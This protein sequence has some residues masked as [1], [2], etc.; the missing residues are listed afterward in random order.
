MSAP[1]F[2]VVMPVYNVERYLR[3]AADSVLGQAFRDF[4]L[5]LVDD[6]SSDGSRA[7]CDEIA[8]AD[9]RVRV[10]RR[11]ENGGLGAARNTGMDGAAGKYIFFM[12]SD[13]TVDA[14]LLED[15][16]RALDENPAEVTVFGVTEEYYTPAGE[17]DHSN[18]VDC[19]EECRLS[20]YGEVRAAVLPMEEKQ[21]FGYVWNKIYRADYLK[22]NGARFENIT[23]IEDVQFNIRVFRDLAGLNI[24]ATRP[25]HYKKR[26]SESLTGRFIPDYFPALRE[27]VRLF[28]ELFFGWD[29]YGGAEKRA[30]GMFYARYVFS[31]LWRNCD[32]RAG[33]NGERRRAFLKGVY[34]DPLFGELI[35]FAD[36]D[37]RS[38]RL[39][40]RLLRGRRTNLCLIMGRLIYIL[41]KRF[42]ML[43]AKETTKR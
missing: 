36:G 40:T 1:F 10:I 13:D 8:G 38:V 23:L 42:P 31:A 15:A 17:L 16:A 35:P 30:L 26:R 24:L 27:R 34:A 14:T 7:L 29:M 2:S 5:I 28:R 11:P 39:M 37:S 41:R 21:L 12:D 33:M 20:G 43:Y 32:P 6:A 25:Y 9:S 4:E 22:N 18:S 19:G 3:E